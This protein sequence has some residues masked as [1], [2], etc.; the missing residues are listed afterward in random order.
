MRPVVRL[1]R[2]GSGVWPDCCCRH[3]MNINN[4]YEKLEPD[5]F[6]CF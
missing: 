1:W 5:S 2:I 4:G 6:R 3:W